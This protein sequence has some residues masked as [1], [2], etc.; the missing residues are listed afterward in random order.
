MRLL[1]ANAPRSYREAMAGAIRQLRPG[2]EVSTVDPTELDSSIQHFA[3]DMVICSEATDEVKRRVPVWV[4]LYP[5]HGTLS[6][7]SVRGK[8]TEYDEIQLPDL[9]SIVDMAEDLSR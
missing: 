5:G 3:P 6:I 9:L 2:A 4:E 7:A 1:I 8:R